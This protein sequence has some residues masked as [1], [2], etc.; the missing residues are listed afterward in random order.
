MVAAA[1]AV[2]MAP[3]WAEASAIVFEGQNA[4]LFPGANPAAN[5]LLMASVNK[6]QNTGSPPAAP[7]LLSDSQIL[8]QSVLSAAT[9]KLENQIFAG[10]SGSK[11]LGGG[12][13]ISWNTVGGVETI[14]FND[15]GAITT[16]QIPFTP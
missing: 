9:A 11:D 6:P 14:T 10:G 13:T 7:S 12:H 15:N 16:I 8:E 3:G 5:A 1:V 2:A 4:A